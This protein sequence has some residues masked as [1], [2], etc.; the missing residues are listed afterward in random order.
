M[1]YRTIVADP[2]WQ[3][4][5]IN[6]DAPRYIDD[7]GRLRSSGIHRRGAALGYSVMTLDEIRAVP[8]GDLAEANA[9]LFLWTTNRYLRHAWSVLESWGFDPQNRVL[10]WCKPPRA[11]TPITTE[12]ILIGKRGKPPRIPWHGTTWFNWPFQPTH[13]QKPEAFLDLVEQWCPGPYLE[14]FAR[15]NRLGWDTWGNEALNH[16]DLSSSSDQAPAPNPIYDYRNDPSIE[17]QPT[18]CTSGEC[19]ECDA[20]TSNGYGY[21]EVGE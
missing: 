17:E 13:S 15:R 19:G 8:V 20:C 3:Y 16:V 7:Q 4:E 9:R 12:F 11:T 10:V 5:K 18:R 6:P 14:L 1:K 21:L 2:P